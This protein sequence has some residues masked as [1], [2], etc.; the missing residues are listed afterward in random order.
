MNFDDRAVEGY[1]LDF[2]PHD[3]CLLQALE[4]TIQDAVLRPAVH[5]G[6]DRVPVPET[7]R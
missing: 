5:S 2:D 1:G 7:L 3:L 4:D 6:V